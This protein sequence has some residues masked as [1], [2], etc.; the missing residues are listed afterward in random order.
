[1]ACSL[2]ECGKVVERDPSR[3]FKVIKGVLK[4]PKTMLDIRNSKNLAKQH[5]KAGSCL[6]DGRSSE[7]THRCTRFRDIKS[8]LQLCPVVLGK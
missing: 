1:M 3:R 2:A 6:C 7:Y 4:K 5:R 8:L